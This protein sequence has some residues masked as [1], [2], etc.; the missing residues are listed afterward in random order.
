LKRSIRLSKEFSELKGG[1]RTR[2]LLEIIEAKM[3]DQA[4]KDRAHKI[5][6]DCGL[7]SKKKKSTKKDNEDDATSGVEHADVLVFTTSEAIQNIIRI[8]SNRDIADDDA[9]NAVVEVI[10]NYVYSP[11][12]ALCGRMLKI[13]KIKSNTEVEAAL[14]VAHAISTHTA[15]PEIDYFVAADDF[16]GEESGAGHVGESLFASACFYKYFSIDWE[17]LVTNLNGND[18][19]AAHTVGAFILA[20]AKTNPSGKQNS[21]AAHN[22][23]DCIIVEVKDSPVSY[24]NAFAKPITPVKDTDLV[25]LSIGKMA[26]Y[27]RDINLGYSSEPIGNKAIWFSPNGRY[28]LAR[29]IE[30]SGI[31]EEKQLDELIKKTLVKIG[32]YNWEEVKSVNVNTGN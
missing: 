18:V 10:T 16:P 7:V 19:L 12:M 25:D 29:Y 13:D 14:Q 9:Q 20:A 4:L 22:Y 30:D 15:R 8:I 3:D 5:L 2:K 17:Q 11:D 32:G 21:Y 26:T 1:I 24:A 31:P 23:P 6:L 28:P 27:M